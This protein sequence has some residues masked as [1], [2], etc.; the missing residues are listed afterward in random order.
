MQEI[1][2]N[3]LKRHQNRIKKM[4]ITKLIEK[5]NSDLY[6]NLSLAI[7][8]N[9]Y[10]TKGLLAFV[11]KCGAWSEFDGSGNCENAI[12][13]YINELY[14]DNEPDYENWSDTEIDDMNGYA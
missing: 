2:I 5:T 6:T 11:Y 1:T 12:R 9:E 3:N 13:E 8:C 10:R 14:L 4:T 7:F